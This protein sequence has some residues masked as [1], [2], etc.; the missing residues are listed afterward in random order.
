MPSAPLTPSGLAVRSVVVQPG[1]NAELTERQR[2]P[3]PLQT[4]RRPRVWKELHTGREFL[5]NPKGSF[6]KTTKKK[7]EGRLLQMDK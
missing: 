3:A 5:L 7:S 2:H 4:Q 1:T 6:I